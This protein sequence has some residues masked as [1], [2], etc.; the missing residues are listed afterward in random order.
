MTLPLF[1]GFLAYSMAAWSAA[2]EEMPTEIPSFLARY[3]IIYSC[4]EDIRD[5]ACADTL[6]LVRACLA[7]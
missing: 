7:F 4:V 1:S 3:F 5:E 2:P 6:D